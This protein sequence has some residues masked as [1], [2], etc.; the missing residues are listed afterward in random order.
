MSAPGRLADHRWLVVVAGFSASVVVLLAADGHRPRPI[1]R[2]L[3]R[4]AV[5]LRSPAIETMAR[6]IS[7]LGD[8]VYLTVLAVVAGL[9]L[10]RRWR[11]PGDGVVPLAALLLGSIIEVTLKRVVGRPRPPIRLHLVPETNPSFP[12]GHV[13]GTAS[14][15]FAVALLLVP[16]LHHPVARGAAL[17]GGGVLALLVGAARVLLGVHWPTDVVAGWFL[18]LACAATTVLAT[19]IAVAEHRSRRRGSSVGY[20]GAGPPPSRDDRLPTSAST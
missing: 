11:S 19:E 2:D 17:V 15:C 7:H 8:P 13:T 1:D 12:S 16:R 4:R 6:G 18:G 10:W 3:L 20:P 14:L 5:R 9:L